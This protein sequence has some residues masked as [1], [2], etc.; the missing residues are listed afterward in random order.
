MRKVPLRLVAT[1]GWV[2]GLGY[3]VESSGFRGSFVSLALWFLGSCEREVARRAS[4]IG[5]KSGCIMSGPMPLFDWQNETRSG[6]LRRLMIWLMPAVE[7]GWESVSRCQLPAA[8]S[9]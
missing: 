3:Q 5:G 2:E 6:R 4:T 7:G 9:F 1:L 8:Q